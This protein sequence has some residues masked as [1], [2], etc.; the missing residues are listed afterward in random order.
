MSVSHPNQHLFLSFIPVFLSA[1]DPGDQVVQ[2][3]E[4]Q[5]Q[6]HGDVAE[7]AAVVPTGSDHGGEALHAASQQT[8]RTQEVGVLK[9]ERRHE[10]PSPPTD[11]DRWPR[12]HH[13]VQVVILILCLPVYVVRQLSEQ[14]PDST[15]QTEKNI[16]Q[17]KVQKIN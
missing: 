15:C 16:Q 9:R 17:R 4:N 6:T 13:T 14:R 2:H 3:K 5:N 1:V 7:D 11:P 12:T 10:K 8:C